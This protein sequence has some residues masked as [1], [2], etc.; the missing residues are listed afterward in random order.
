[1]HRGETTSE[2]RDRVRRLENRRK[3]EQIRELE[4]RKHSSPVN[5]RRHQVSDS[6]D[7]DIHTLKN[8]VKELKIE[9]RTLREVLRR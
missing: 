6:D 3:I 8:R 5:R 9:N 4:R 2:D 1:M 7:E